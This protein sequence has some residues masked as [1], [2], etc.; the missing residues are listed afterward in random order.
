MLSLGFGLDKCVG[1]CVNKLDPTIS[2][3]GKLKNRENRH[4]DFIVYAIPGELRY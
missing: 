4:I 2:W 3:P 1:K